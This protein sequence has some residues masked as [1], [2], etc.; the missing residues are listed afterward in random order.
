LP[1]IPEQIHIAKILTKAE[2][3]IS[4]RKESIR[5]LDEFLKSSFLE[6]FIDE[7]EFKE[8]GGLITI[9]ELVGKEKHSIKA[10][11]FGSSLKKEFYVEKGYKIYGQEQV[12][13]DNFT[14]GNYYINEEIFKKLES[15]RIKRGDLLISLVGTYGKISIVPEIFE[16]GILNPRLMKIS[17]D[18][19][20]INPLYFKHLFRSSFLQ[21]Q[22][23]RYSR[24][25]TMDIINV[26]IVKEL[27]IPKPPLEL[28][29][30][31]AQIA[32]KIEAL[33]VQYQQSLKELENLYGSLNQRAF[34][35]ELSFKDEKLMMAAEPYA[36]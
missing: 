21:D 30:Q 36:T 1:P 29:T 25:G 22:I 26:G 10:G 2:N 32:E 11:P 5:L 3:L 4:Q 7:A 12:I 6:M 23:S 18:K 31:F 28:Q 19:N 9:K 20:N 34:K 15:C 33:K 17:F 16:P 24:G 27:A 14:I 13:A 8:W 35:E